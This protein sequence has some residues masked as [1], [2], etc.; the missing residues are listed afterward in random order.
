MA[1]SD[2]RAPNRP[3]FG[4]AALR[5]TLN[6]Y[7]L[8]LFFRTSLPNNATRYQLY[9]SPVRCGPGGVEIHSLFMCQISGV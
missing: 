2:L 9:S 5:L 7:R 1:P 3:G 6:K 8:L 4:E